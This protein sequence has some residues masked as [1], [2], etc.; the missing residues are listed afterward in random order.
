MAEVD[1]LVNT[2]PLGMEGQSRLALDLAPLKKSAV[3]CDVVYVPLTT[4]LLA[5][6]R[7]RGNPTVDG[8]G[9][10]MHQA[11]PGFQRWFGVRPEVTP[12]LRALLLTD[13]GE[14][15]P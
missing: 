10:L 8:L 5:A 7:A 13:L 14:K 4:E 9:M 12:K 15:A 1:L 11:V 2:T 6:A 3:V